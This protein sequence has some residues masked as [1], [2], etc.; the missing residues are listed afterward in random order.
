MTENEANMDI[1]YAVCVLESIGNG[2]ALKNENDKKDACILAIQAI[3]K[4][5]AFEAIG[6]IEEF[7]ALKEKNEPKKVSDIH[8]SE[9]SEDI[10]YFGADELFGKCP[11][12]NGAVNHSWNPCGC[13][14][15]GGLID[16]SE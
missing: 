13:G 7:K 8:K 15:C 2:L 3:D 16:W 12:C 10:E 11:H 6:T 1:K 4:V 14:D 5:Q 9:Y